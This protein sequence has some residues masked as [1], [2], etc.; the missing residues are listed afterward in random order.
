MEI[1]YWWLCLRLQYLYCISN[2]D[3]AVLHE[4]SSAYMDGLMK[5][6]SIS[7]VLAVEILQS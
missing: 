2:G 3:N 5:N 7:S 6:H 4:A 1:M